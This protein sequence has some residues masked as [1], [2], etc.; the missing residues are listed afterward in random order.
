[1]LA[2]MSRIVVTQVPVLYGVPFGTY[3]LQN[4]T[5][6]ANI[7][8]SDITAAGCP[9]VTNSN[10]ISA[11]WSFLKIRLSP[12]WDPVEIGRGAGVIHGAVGGLGAGLSLLP[13]NMSE[14]CHHGETPNIPSNVIHSSRLDNTSGSAINRPDGSFDELGLFLQ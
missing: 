4:G 10:T 9:I 1:M 8:P 5:K 14:S 11:W 7:I 6:N 13:F 12:P 3:G 2:I